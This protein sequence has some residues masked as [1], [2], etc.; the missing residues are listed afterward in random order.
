M[1]CGYGNTFAVLSRSAWDFYSEGAY[2]SDIVEKLGSIF[3]S[4]KI[5]IFFI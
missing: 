5:L 2:Y 4:S 1:D 3:F